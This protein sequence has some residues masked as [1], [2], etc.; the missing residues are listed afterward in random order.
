MHNYSKAISYYKTA[1]SGASAEESYSLRVDL[2]SL[3]QKLKR[4]EECQVIIEE[5]LSNL[6][7]QSDTLQK[8]ADLKQMKAELFK[9]MEMYPQALDTYLQSK[10]SQMILLSRAL[11]KDSEMVLN[12]IVETCIRMAEIS[13]LYLKD[14]DKAISF[15]NEAA[16][17]QEKNEKALLA[18]SKLYIR[19]NNTAS[20]QELLQTVLKN[21]PGSEEASELMG[22][23]LFGTASFQSALY[24]YYQILEKNPSNFE[25]L[26]KYVDVCRRTNKLEL[27]D[28]I[29]NKGT[30]STS[31]AKLGVG[32][33]YCRGIYFRH[34]SRLNEALKEFV[35]CKKDN[36]WGE[37]TMIQMVEI[38]LNPGN[39]TIGGDALASAID[40]SASTSNLNTEAELLGAITAEKLLRVTFFNCRSLPQ[41]Q[42]LYKLKFC[43]VK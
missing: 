5:A 32:Y 19:R 10:E 43:I 37:R 26:A 11:D 42:I 28:E 35:L 34:S 14:Y 16:H 7:S 3:L 29:L 39:E 30:L 2:A 41:R 33:H 17:H 13:E 15:Y 4:Y 23:L 25:V 31:K 40:N 36:I 12:K 21:F 9:N 6:Q 8:E 38:F 24:H 22:D 27:A 18:L 20:A 1:I